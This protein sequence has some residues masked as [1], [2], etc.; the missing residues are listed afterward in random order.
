VVGG[1]VL[2]LAVAVLDVVE[3]AFMVAN[4]GKFSPDVLAQ[5]I[6]GSYNRGETFNLAM[7]V[8]HCMNYA[9]VQAYDSK[10]ALRTWKEAS[11]PMF[12]PVEHINSYRRFLLLAD[13]GHVELTAVSVSAEYAKRYPD[14]GEFFKDADLRD[15]IA[16]LQ[17]RSLPAIIRSVLDGTYCGV[18]AGVGDGCGGLLYAA[19]SPARL[20]PREVNKLR[21]VRI[22]KKMRERDEYWLEQSVYQKTQDPFEFCEAVGKAAPYCTSTIPGQCAKLY[23]GARWA[24]IK[25]QY[26]KYVPQ[27]YVPD[28]YAINPNG[29]SGQLNSNYME[30]LDN[31]TNV[32]PDPAEEGVMELRNYCKLTDDVELL[33]LCP[34]NASGGRAT[35]KPNKV[36]ELT[37][38]LECCIGARLKPGAVKRAL[39]R[40]VIEGILAQLE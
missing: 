38:Q 27:R 37:E 32:D 18:G 3:L 2:L 29:L 25:E 15:Q 19:E 28:E 14:G 1:W 26:A 33:S 10:S 36:N 16:A 35:V 11:T 4:H 30:Q 21:T 9:S 12:K 6:A 34:S 31:A 13:D 5:K 39:K 8:Q 24:Q 7:L 23:R 20:L 22:F 17:T 40:L